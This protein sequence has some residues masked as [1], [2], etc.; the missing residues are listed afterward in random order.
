MMKLAMNLAD[1]SI[2][3]RSAVKIESHPVP[4]R[5]VVEDGSL[6]ILRRLS[7]CTSGDLTGQNVSDRECLSCAQE[8]VGDLHCSHSKPATLGS[9]IPAKAGIQWQVSAF[10]INSHQTVE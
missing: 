7:I 4:I 6:N 8:T 5:K 10:N 9:V 2:E 3:L 1:T